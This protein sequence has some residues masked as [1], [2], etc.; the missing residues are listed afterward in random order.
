M[1]KIL[2][3]IINFFFFN[4]NIKNLFLGQKFAMHQMKTII[5]TVIRKMKIETLGS[6]DDIKI[7]AQLI[8]RPE[9]LPDIKL[10]KIK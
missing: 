10:T 6:Q 1:F 4:F 5:S 3:N 2:V 9:S 8:L 7:G